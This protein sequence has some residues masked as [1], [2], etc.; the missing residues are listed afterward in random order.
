MDKNLRITF[1][2]RRPMATNFSV[3][4]VFDGIRRALP[5]EI[6]SNVVIAPFASR[7]LLP[8]LYNICAA[9]FYQGDVNHITGDVHYL[10]YFLRKERTLLTILDCVSLRRLTGLRKQLLFFFW[11]WLPEKRSRLISVI[12]ESTRKELLQYLPHAVEKIRV[13]PCPVSE[14]FKSSPK[15]F[16]ASYP[17]LLQIGT[18]LNKNLPRVIE[19]LN[20]IRCHLRIIGRLAPEQLVL[21]QSNPVDYSSVANITD[22]EIVQ[23]YC[24][25][26]MV[27]FASTYEG[28]G[29]PILEAQATGRPV[30]T[31]NLLSMP[32]V[33]GEAA[34]YVDPYDVNS[35]RAGVMRIIENGCYREQL[36]EEGFRNVAKYQPEIIAEQYVALYREITGRGNDLERIS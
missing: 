9:P 22:S 19:A 10:T 16:N 29:L 17:T 7:G 33:A 18:G 15:I 32:E 24:N 13:V 35:I 28:F 5:P 2:H 31:S 30:V 27:I 8:R 3:E 34:S 1:Y 12:S 21:L 23:E 36:V 6:E 14:D 4:R 26:D 11:Y 25:A 20:G